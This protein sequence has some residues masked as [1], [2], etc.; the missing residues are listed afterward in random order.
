[1]MN[2]PFYEV[3][4]KYINAAASLESKG[5]VLNAWLSAESLCNLL[6]ESDLCP[7]GREYLSLGLR[8]FL[9]EA[10][11]N[12]PMVRAMVSSLFLHLMRMNR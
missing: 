5:D 6:K 1:M 12:A 8:V 3:A 7:N 2:P 9:M 10:P 11:P 4:L